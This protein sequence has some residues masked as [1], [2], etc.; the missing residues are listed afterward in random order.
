MRKFLEIFQKYILFWILLVVGFTAVFLFSQEFFRDHNAK[1]VFLNVGQGD[2]ILIL[3]PNGRKVLVDSGKYGDISMKVSKYLAM[4]DRSL[5]LVIATHPDIDHIA[6]FNELLDEYEIKQFVHSGLLAGAP[7]YRNIAKKVRK[8]HIPAH[9]AVAGEKIFLDKDM[10]LEVLSPYEGQK[11]EEPN[12]YS[13]VVRLVYRDNAI[14]LTGDASKEVEQ[15]LLKMYGEGRL[16][17]EVLKLGHHGSKTSSDEKF[18]SAVHP[19]YGIIS[20]GCNNKYG[21][22]HVSVLRAL[23]EQGIEEVNTCEHGDIVFI[24]DGKKWALQ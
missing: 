23:D 13:V 8:Y 22:P 12:D 1:V 9:N 3:T 11:I 19:Q 2:A 17:A 20:A 15:N 7:V 18:I 5:D 6:G 4:S 14:L 10:Y 16:S 21:H 24:F